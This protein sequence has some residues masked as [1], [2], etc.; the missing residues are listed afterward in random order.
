[1]FDSR[2]SASTLDGPGTGFYVAA[3]IRP[4]QS[5]PRRQHG[6]GMSNHKRSKRLGRL[7]R[8]RAMSAVLAPLLVGMYVFSQNSPV[9]N[10]GKSS[11]KLE[12]ALE[13]LAYSSSP[14]GSAAAN[15]HTA[16][17]TPAPTLREKHFPRPG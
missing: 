8:R 16:I 2:P 11:G 10:S 12:H 13:I 14:T 17:A 4:F 5:P 7:M 15:L 6:V 1:M 9:S 3:E